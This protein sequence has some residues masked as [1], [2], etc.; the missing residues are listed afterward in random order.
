MM[1]NLILFLFASYLML[2]SGFTADTFIE[3]SNGEKIPVS[4]IKEWCEEQLKVGS[5]AR[6]AIDA[7]Q[8]LIKLKAEEAA[9]WKDSDTS[10]RN[11]LSAQ[12][13]LIRS[14]KQMILSI[15]DEYDVIVKN[16][17]GLI[18]IGQFEAEQ[19]KQFGDVPKWDPPKQRPEQIPPKPKGSLLTDAEWV[20]YKQA[21]ADAAAAEKAIAEGHTTYAQ[22]KK[23]ALEA[24]AQARLRLAVMKMKITK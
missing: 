17:E 20:A 23:D 19:I 2:S 21:E 18:L 8:T 1:K 14:Q 12:D 22:A 9:I 6:K 10:A 15:I 13:N 7:A 16:Q 24:I 4:R 3:L 11:V 5:S